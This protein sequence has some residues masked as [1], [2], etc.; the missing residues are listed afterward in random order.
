MKNHSE[1]RIAESVIANKRVRR[2]EGIKY[3]VFSLCT[4][5]AVTGVAGN[6]HKSG[7]GISDRSIVDFCNQTP[8]IENDRR[9]CIDKL[10]KSQK[11]IN[12]QMF[13][14]C[15]KHLSAMDQKITCIVEFGDINRF[16]NASGVFLESLCTGDSYTR[17]GKRLYLTDE[18]KMKCISD[19]LQPGGQNSNQDEV[20]Q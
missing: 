4:I 10:K 18:E 6:D 19:K 17:G 5:V 11:N 14:F 8:K 12:P 7:G 15:K 1:F 20:A 13:N 16:P 2:K 3:W 9:D